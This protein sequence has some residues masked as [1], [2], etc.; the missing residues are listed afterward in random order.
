MKTT[1]HNVFETNSSST[2]SISIN[3][4]TELYDSITPD[5]NGVITLT[6]GEFGWE[7]KQ[8]NDA[9]TKANYCAID[10]YGNAE[11][12]KMLRDVIM[13][14]TG[15]KDV[16]FAFTTDYRKD[17][18][19]YIDHQ[20][21]GTSH[22]A[23]SS[24][25]NLKN[26]IFNPKSYLFT[27]NDNNDE[28]ANFYDVDVDD[29][30]HQIVLEG[31]SGVYKIRESDINDTDKIVDAVLNL[32]S[33]NVYNQYNSDRTY[34]SSDSEKLYS[35]P[36]CDENRGVDI[37]NRRLKIVKKTAVYKKNGDF[38]K[39]RLDDERFLKY[40]IDRISTTPTS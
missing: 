32:F 14:H 21:F 3:S 25:D 12:E 18:Y 9:L 31:S 2:H 27:G 19:S 17:T 29:F 39:Y 7:W 40:S 13:E 11:L 26:F 36:R 28:P 10:V 15:A 35:T 34:W 16:V 8:Y 6:G 5:A 38:D 23:F 24:S 30:T 33:R 1:R 37:A 4:T 20:S 22:P